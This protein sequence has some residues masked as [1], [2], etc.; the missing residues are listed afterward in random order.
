MLAVPDGT[1]PIRALARVV[2]ITPS[3]DGADDVSASFVH[4]D[5]ENRIRLTSYLRNLALRTVA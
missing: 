4:I 5:N 1:Q 3:G 2:G